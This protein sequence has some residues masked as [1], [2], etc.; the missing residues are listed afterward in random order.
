MDSIVS[1]VKAYYRGHM[2][3]SFLPS[4]NV[5]KVAHVDR[6]AGFSLDLPLSAVILYSN[7]IYLKYT[8][9]S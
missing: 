5:Q 6:S 9:M 3:Y 4:G 8:D 2:C 7:F 1:L